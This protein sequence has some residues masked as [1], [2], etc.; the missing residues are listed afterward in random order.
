MVKIAGAPTSSLNSPTL[1]IPP[2]TKTHSPASLS[3]A[4]TTKGKG[5][6]TSDNDDSDREITN[7]AVLEPNG[8]YVTVLENM[9]NLAPILDAALVDTDGS[10][11]V[12]SLPYLL[13][14]IRVH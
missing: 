4:K 3:R 2:D 11:Q 10:G 13:T 6:A 7:G 5:K 9:K 8:S 14:I 1:R 12:C